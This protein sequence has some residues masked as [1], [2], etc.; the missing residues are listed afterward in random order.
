MSVDHLDHGILLILLSP[1]G[2]HAHLDPERGEP[3]GRLGVPA[4]MHQQGDLG[5]PGAGLPPGAGV[6]PELLGFRS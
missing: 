2:P 1:D 6:R 4:V 5:Q 3:D